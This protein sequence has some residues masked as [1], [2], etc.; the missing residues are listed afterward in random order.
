MGSTKV[1]VTVKSSGSVI[2]KLASTEQEA[3]FGETETAAS[4]T[5]TLYTPVDNPV[6]DVGGDAAKAPVG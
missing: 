5:M 6:S 1:A 2:L 3:F 4:C